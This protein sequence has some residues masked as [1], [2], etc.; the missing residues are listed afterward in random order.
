MTVAGVHIVRAARAGKPIRWHIYAWRGGPKIRMAQQPLRPSLTRDDIAAIA[1]AHAADQ[2]R[3]D[4]INGLSIA[5]QASPD[6]KALAR[7]T[8][9]LWGG[10]LVRIEQ[11]WG[12]VPLRLW[13]DP[14]MTAKLV[15]WRDSMAAT[16]RAADVHIMVLGRMLVWGQLHGLVTINAAA[17]VPTLWKG[18]HREEIIWLPH[19]CAAFDAVPDAPQWLIDARKLAEF[20]GL[21][22]AD[23]VALSWSDITD[24]HI[25]RTAAKKSQGK[26]RRTIMP[27][28]PGLRELLAELK[29]RHR[30]PGVETVLVGTR[31]R[32]IKPATLT[33]EFIKHRH[34]A[35]AGQGIHHPGECGDPPRA[36]SLHDFRG[37][38]ATKLMTLPGGSL[39]DDQI[40]SVMGWSPQKVAAIR[41]RYVDEAAII[42]AIATRI[43]AGQV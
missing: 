31:G 22:R 11:K 34:Q 36:K 15:G 38:F 12:E 42:V 26:R 23:L 4:T 28:V 13:N 40:A 9:L 35:N 33:V 19:D 17:P 39:T 10:A 16:P 29:T 43:A 20:T 14:R 21:R 7:S 3:R 2:P 18:G 25:A 32:A 8:R 27:I 37:T 41:K 24:T 1:A 6:W 5:W 30:Q